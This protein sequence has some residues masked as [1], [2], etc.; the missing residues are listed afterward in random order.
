MAALEAAPPTL[1]L[2]LAT[3]TV[4][5]TPTPIAARLAIRRVL[6]RLAETGLDFPV[7][8]PL[9]FLAEAT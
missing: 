5:A 3:S 7:P 8:D 9:R 1:P 2:R 4:P 6:R